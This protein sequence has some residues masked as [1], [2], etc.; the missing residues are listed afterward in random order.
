MRVTY[1]KRFLQDLN[2]IPNPFKKKIQEIVFEQ[3]PCTD[4][5]EQINGVKKMKGYTEFYRIR[6][7][8]YRIG[9]SVKEDRV[10]FF[11]VLHR[12]DIYKYFP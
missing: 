4:N 5:F 3:I 2:R 11:R 7:S 8:D 12:K 6:F 1:K 9:L 10:V